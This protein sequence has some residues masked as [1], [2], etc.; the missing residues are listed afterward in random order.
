MTSNDFYIQKINKDTFFVYNTHQG[1]GAKFG[2]KSKFYFDI[3]R[4]Y[5]D[6]ETCLSLID[7]ELKDDFLL[8]YNDLEKRGFLN[9]TPLEIKINEKTNFWSFY[10]HLTD[11]CNLKCAY[12]YNHSYRNSKKDLSLEDWKIIIDKIEPSNKKIL[13]T[14]GEPFLYKDLNVLI[15]YIHKKYPTAILNMNSNGNIDFEKIGALDVLRNIDNINLSCDNIKDSLHER[16]GF[17]SILFKKNIEW[18]IKSGFKDKLTIASVFS[19]N[20]ESGIK[21]VRSYCKKNNIRFQW[22]LR[23][24]TS[25]SQVDV[26]NLPTINQY[27]KF[28]LHGKKEI[29]DKGIVIQTKCGAATQALSIDPKGDCYPCQVFHFPEMKMGNLLTDNMNTIAKSHIVKIFQDYHI[30]KKETCKDCKIRYACGAGCIADTY[31]L[32]GD[33]YKCPEILCDYY[34]TSTKIYFKCVG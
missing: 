17:N 8:F 19:K 15:D 24:P 33:I 13:I 18:L 25:V 32:H 28:L 31:K 21:N 5:H 9:T 23:L 27:K 26:E 2:L 20:Y 16:I 22:A 7:D 3:V 34:K 30:D 4:K 6:K 29:P 14:G 12:C 1:I 10:V 11:N